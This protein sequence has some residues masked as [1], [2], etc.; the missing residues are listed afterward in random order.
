LIKFLSMARYGKA[1]DGYRNNVIDIYALKARVYPMVIF[2][3]PVVFL[4]I[5]NSFQFNDLE[6]LFLSVIITGTLAFILSQTG[7][8][9]GKRKEKGLWD[10]WGGSPTIQLM[11]HR[12]TEINS[13]TKARYFTKLNALCALAVYPDANLEQNDPGKA[14][15]IY[16]FWSS[17]LRNNSRNQKKFNLL[18]RET[19]NYGFRRNLWGMKNLS[20]RLITILLVMNYFY[21][22][23]AEG[24]FNLLFFP[25]TFTI[26]FLIL[27]ALLVFWTFY[28]SKEWVR[29][30]AFTY[31]HRL[32]E[33]TDKL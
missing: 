11:R 32:L 7:R 8:D 15:E 19:T 2:F 30:V 18:F 23:L 4:M 12:N 1:G 5:V 31:A 33:A 27:V 16:A 24:H 26:N 14:D 3:L 28:I 9:K 25:E 13:A 20:I 21:F 22:V 6:Q 29:M 17:Y 10:S